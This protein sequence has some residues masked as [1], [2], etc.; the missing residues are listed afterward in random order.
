LYRRSHTYTGHTCLKPPSGRLSIQGQTEPIR[1]MTK[2]NHRLWYHLLGASEERNLRE[3][4][5][6]EKM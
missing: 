4:N 1:P 3:T 5:K 6:N 2:T